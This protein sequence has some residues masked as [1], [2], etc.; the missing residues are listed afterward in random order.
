MNFLLVQQEGQ[1]PLTG[2][3]APTISGGT[4]SRRR[5]LIDGY[6]ESPFPTA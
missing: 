4:Y 1:H 3:R 2:Q 6:L 5:T